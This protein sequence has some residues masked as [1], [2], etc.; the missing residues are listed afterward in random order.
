MSSV[1]PF[2]FQ[3]EKI[4]EDDRDVH[5]GECPI[6]DINMHLN[7]KAVKFGTP[8]PDDIP[9]EAKRSE[10][11]ASRV[12]SENYSYL[13]LVLQKVVQPSSLLDTCTDT[14]AKKQTKILSK[15]R[16][17]KDNIAKLFKTT[18]RV[19]PA[20]ANLGPFAIPRGRQH[21]VQDVHPSP[22][23][24]STSQR[25]ISRVRVVTVLDSHPSGHTR[26]EAITS[27]VAYS[28]HAVEEHVDDFLSVLRCVAEAPSPSSPAQ[29]LTVPE[30]QR[31]LPSTIFLNE[32]YKIEEEVENPEVGAEGVSM[33]PEELAV[34][35]PC[36]SLTTS[37][38]E[39]IYDE[40]LAAE[41]ATFS[42]D[43]N[44]IQG[45]SDEV[46]REKEAKMVAHFAYVSKALAVPVPKLSA[47]FATDSPA[48]FT[49]VERDEFFGDPSP[50]KTV[51]SEA[52]TS[53]ADSSL[54]TSVDADEDRAS[55][56]PIILRGLRRIR[57][58]DDLRVCLLQYHYFISFLTSSIQNLQVM[59]NCSDSFSDLSCWSFDLDPSDPTPA[60]SKAGALR[61]SVKCN[62]LRVC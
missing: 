18:G 3:T 20:I 44:D 10:S 32:L 34:S 43:S 59:T 48:D 57:S 12:I 15:V 9:S 24:T 28:E 4:F 45:W 29:C 49:T 61:R 25:A 19:S 55:L 42:F 35:S 21:G 27:L 30:T 36:G 38:S 37:D 51:T 1:N 54:V 2:K 39:T 22:P 11:T 14:Q 62:D 53:S 31:R 17:A 6:A 13:T 46:E 60:G 41:F 40:M 52:N 16:S 8:I 50:V 26:L 7:K 47:Y 58:H 5:A 23:W 33:E 56:S